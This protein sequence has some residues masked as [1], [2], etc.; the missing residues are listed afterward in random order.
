ME[1]FTEELKKA[2]FWVLLITGSLCL[3]FSAILS[4]NDELY[5]LTLP[6]SERLPHFYTPWYRTAGVWAEVLHDI[7][8]ACLIALLILILVERA[9]RIEQR[10]S[11]DELL[12]QVTRNM[13]E[14][15]YGV[16]IGPSIV[17][18]V[19]AKILT[20]PI[21]RTNLMVTYTLQNL[22][23]QREVEESKY[24]TLDVLL[25]YQL[26][27]VSA[28]PV[29]WPIQI[30]LPRPNVSKLDEL[31]MVDSCSFD[32]TQLSVAEISSACS[33]DEPWERHYRWTRSIERGERLRVDLSYSVIKEI[34]DNEIW[35]SL[36]TTEGIDFIVENRIKEIEW[37]IS[38]RTS[39]RIIQVGGARSKPWRDCR[40][41]FRAT[42][43]LIANEAITVF[44]RPTSGN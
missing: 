44:W 33:E 35:T 8:F 43:P 11:A 17:K 4:R 13:L 36:L 19:I 5:V 30:F 31:V 3:V 38:P 24:I 29:E 9:T 18:H 16:N 25:S 12:R 37:S 28:G 6:E 23:H 40:I 7:G 22:P 15:S 27:N 14:A 41:V 39:S 34:S 32:G 42:D 20:A 26:T 21:I 1:P 2:R 10:R